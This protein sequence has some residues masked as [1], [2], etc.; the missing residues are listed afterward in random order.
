M[1]LQFK[2]QFR[3]KIISTFDIVEGTSFY[4]LGNCKENCAVHLSAYY[5]PHWGDIAELQTPSGVI[6]FSAEEFLGIV[7]D[8]LNGS[9]YWL[10]YSLL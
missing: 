1:V 4:L 10:M 2:G 6:L 8:F 7:K 5:F 9:D 3:N